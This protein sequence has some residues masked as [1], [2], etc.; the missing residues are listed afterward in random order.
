MLRAA[1]DINLQ[2]N[3]GEAPLHKAVFN[4]AIRYPL[5]EALITHKAHVNVKNNFGETPLHYAVHLG[6]KDLVTLLVSH[7]A[8]IFLRGNKD[9]K[10]PY[11]LAL[12][13]NHESIANLL[14]KC[15]GNAS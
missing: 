8:D 3:I 13:W 6:R 9:N 5:V 1:A 4:N 12:Q 10:T 11:E 14:K 7:G 2:N 15:H